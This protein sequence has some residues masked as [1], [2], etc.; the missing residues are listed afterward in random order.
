MENKTF[1]LFSNTIFEIRLEEFNHR[2]LK[3]GNFYSG[4]DIHLFCNIPTDLSLESKAY[5]FLLLFFLIPFPVLNLSNVVI[6]FP[7][8]DLAPESD[9]L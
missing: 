2:H 8:E 4:T 5:F 7:T 1:Q 9:M 6:L 3:T